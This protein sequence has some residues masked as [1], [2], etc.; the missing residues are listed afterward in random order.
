M[1]PVESIANH[2][3]WPKHNDE[4]WYNKVER[5]ISPLYPH[6]LWKQNKCWI[7]HLQGHLIYNMID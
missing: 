3:K 2:W 4:I 6:P 7:V 5:M 1:H